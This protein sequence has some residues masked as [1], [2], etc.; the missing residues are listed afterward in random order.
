MTFIE[1]IWIRRILRNIKKIE[2]QEPRNWKQ[3]FGTKWFRTKS[4]YQLEIYIDHVKNYNFGTEH[5]N[6]QSFFFFENFEFWISESKKHEI[7]I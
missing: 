6:V 2:S 7:G 5:V 3:I 1:C 4:L